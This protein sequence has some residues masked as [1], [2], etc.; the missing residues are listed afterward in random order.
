[1]ANSKIIGSHW[2]MVEVMSSVED[3]AWTGETKATKKAKNSKE[4]KAIFPFILFQFTV[5]TRKLLLLPLTL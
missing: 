4:A 5:Y 2:V 1:M 3:E